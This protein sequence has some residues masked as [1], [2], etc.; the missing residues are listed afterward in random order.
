MSNQL[1]DE[2]GQHWRHLRGRTY[3]LL[4]N[5]EDA[6]LSKQLPFPE[7]ETLGYQLW[8]MLAMS[9]VLVDG[10]LGNNFADHDAHFREAKENLTVEKLRQ[11]M[12]QSDEKILASLDNI[13]MLKAGDTSMTPLWIYL[14][15]TEH[16]AH[17]H[18]QIINFLYAHHLPIPDSWAEQWALSRSQ[19]DT[20]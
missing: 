6:D 18:G 20:G 1:L 4:E 19:S 8:C 11:A 10:I 9:N 3:D 5:L 16:E 12:K 15:L 13:D 14:Y 2:I 17:H 7:S